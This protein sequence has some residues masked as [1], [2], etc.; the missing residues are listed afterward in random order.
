MATFKQYL[1]D[2]YTLHSQPSSQEYEW[3]QLASTKFV[4][5]RLTLKPME[6]QSGGQ[7]R[8]VALTNILSICKQD[9]KPVKILLEGDAGSGK[10]TISWHACQ[11]WAKGNVFQEFQF[12]IHLSLADPDIQSAASFED[13]IPHPSAEIRK[14]VAEDIIERNGKKCLFVMDGW[15]DLAPTMQASSF[16]RSIIQGNAPGVSLPWC[17]F[18]VTSR[19]VASSSLV[20]CIPST[21]SVEA[22]SADDV[23]SYTT[24]YFPRQEESQ[25]FLSSIK[26]RPSAYS[27]CSLPINLVTMIFI[28]ANCD[29]TLSSLPSTQTELFESLVLVLLLRHIRTKLSCQALTYLPSFSRLPDTLKPAFNSLCQLAHFASFNCQSQSQVTFSLSQLKEANIPTPED[30][31]GLLKVTK[32]L[33][34]RGYAPYYSF[35]HSAV[36]DFLCALW[37]SK[38][39]EDEQQH[40]VSFIMNID[41]MSPVL[42]F[43]AGYTQLK[44]KYQKTLKLLLTLANK[45]VDF[46]RPI[47]SLSLNPHKKADPRRV[48]LSVLHCIYES[49]QEELFLQVKPTNLEGDTMH[50]FVFDHYRLSPFNCAVIGKFVSCVPAQFTGSIPFNLNMDHCKIGDYGLEQFLQPVLFTMR[51]LARTTPESKSS[52][53]LNLSLGDNH[54]THKSVEELKHVLTLQGTVVLLPT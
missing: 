52:K 43:F 28:F 18:L 47:T 50:C 14:A 19:P 20:S 38:T 40:N 3:P 34:L 37:M 1:K 16:L 6:N 4:Q 17:S 54:L 23:T 11:Q 5:P 2:C 51:S 44:G 15:E 21:I 29:P 7:E 10:T 12:V 48:L 41:P 27:L 30:T 46:L 31:L 49:H 53:E 25:K 13:L 42:Q 35:L 8:E 39:N 45:P 26:A 36:Q 33:T 22:F 24:Q 9:N 32:C